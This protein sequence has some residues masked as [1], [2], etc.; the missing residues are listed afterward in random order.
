MKK[1]IGLW[2]ITC[3][4][5]VQLHSQELTQ[6]IRGKIVD[7]QSESPLIGATVIVV[8]T[9][10]IQG[11]VTDLDGEFSIPDVVVGRHDIRATFVGYEEANL[12][13]ILVGSGK[14]PYLN[15][16]LKESF[17]QME[18]VVIVAS[19]QSAG[20]PLNELATVSALSFSVE[21]TSRYAATFNDPARAAQAFAGVST[22]GDD[23]L[24][25]IVI[26]GNS[27]K[28]LLWRIEG[29][30]IPNPNHFSDVGSS[31][32]GISMLSNSMLANSDFFTG[33]FPAEYGNASSGV[34][35]LYLRNG[36]NQKNEYA[37][38]AGFLGLAAAVEGPFKQGGDA[39]YLANY[40]YS[41][42]ALFDDIGVKITEE[43]EDIVFSDLSFKVNLPTRKAGVFSFWGLGGFST[44]DIKADPE[45]GAWLNERSHNKL[46]ILGLN[47]TIY[48]NRD[49]Y[50]ESTLT[51][52]TRLTQY[53]E[54]S[55]KV[56]AEF[57]EEFTESALRFSTLLNQKF[58]SRNTLRSGFI[59]SHLDYDLLSRFYVRELGRLV[60]DVNDSGNTQFLQAYSQWQFRATEKLTMNTGLHYSLLALNNNYSVEPRFGMKYQLRPNEA[61]SLGVGI[62]SRMETPS[63]YLGAIDNGSGILAQPNK[64]LEL[65]KAAHF[66]VGYE[67]SL[68]NNWRFKAEAYYQH[69]Y[70][71]PILAGVNEGSPAEPFQASFSL[72]NVSDGIV[73]GV[74]SNDGEGRNYGLELT[75]E[76]NL[77]NGFY[78]VVTSSL[79]ESKYTPF[80]GKERNTR[81]NA[82]YLFNVISGKEWKVGKGRQNLFS[83]NWKFILS[84][85]NRYI[86]VDLTA[87]RQNGENTLD[88]TRVYD[89]SLNDYWRI[90][91]GVR[92]VRN[93]PK[94]TQIIAI[95]IQNLTG[96]AN[97]SARFYD[98]FQGRIISDTQLALFPNLSYRIEF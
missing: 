45:V 57:E 92:Y 68:A 51:G 26:R 81:F 32:G 6:T 54:D 4:T 49:T 77:R 90:D 13:G 29:V 60:T 79:F 18:E 82:N 28:G 69:L 44:D 94:A 86:P 39:S 65:M 98:A 21:Q 91:L 87:S 1:L 55:L 22:G 61:L 84:G 37:F 2:A 27:P 52:S 58:N 56:R 30:E 15:I 16:K 85:N 74:L 96:R 34:F 50:I 46:G 70:D 41:T 53:D 7:S 9:D 14:Q 78:M 8:G 72:L 33:A 5:V 36:N 76:R 88:F 47:H 89:E 97:E 59:I 35:D 31:A 66:V 43:N 67:R 20:E 3:Y 25:E 71:V 75:A 64:D 42:L 10:P 63:I 93:K 80:D 11:T 62:H 48:L 24:N 83:V 12:P 17:T 23:I 38:Q 95:N 73:T 40:R 19:E